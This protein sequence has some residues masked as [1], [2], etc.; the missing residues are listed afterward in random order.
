MTQTNSSILHGYFDEVVNQKHLDAIPKYMSE[1]FIGHGTP[2]VGMGL[3]IDE[4]SGEKVIIQ[5]VHQG[6]PAEGKLMVGDEILRVFDGERTWSTFEELRQSIWGQGMLGSSLTVWVRRDKAEHEIKL[7]RGLVQGFE[8]P[9]R[10]VESGNREYFKEWPD[11]KARLVNVI[12]AG[13]LVAYHAENQGHNARYG[14]SAIWAEFGFVRFQD[15]KIIDWW[16]VED[17]I[18]QFKQL[19]YTILA[20]AL[21]KA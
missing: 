4:S 7:V 6:S 15:G 3:M 8:F 2:Y 17:G 5:L 10:L 13:D 9:Y 12:E 11:L 16:S 1:K 21:A 14:R 18:S 20:P 19:G